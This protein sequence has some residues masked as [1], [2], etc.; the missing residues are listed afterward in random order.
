MISW[1]SSVGWR[2]VIWQQMHCT[3]VSWRS[4]I[5]PCTQESGGEA[6][7]L[8]AAGTTQVL[9]LKVHHF[10]LLFSLLLCK[11]FRTLRIQPLDNAFKYYSVYSN[12]LDQPPV[13]TCA[14]GPR[15]WGPNWLQFSS[16]THAEKSATVTTRRK[17]H[18]NDRICHLW[19]K[20]KFL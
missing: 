20:N 11:F 7:R 8:E 2:S 4:G 1:K 10:Y 12:F 16:G 19:G 14:K 15:H 13:Q 6:A 9:R 3:A 17:R 5:Q 18:G